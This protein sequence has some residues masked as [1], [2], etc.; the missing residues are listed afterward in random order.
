M[1]IPAL[2]RFSTLGSSTLETR[3]RSSERIDPCE[4]QNDCNIPIV[5][6]EEPESLGWFYPWSV[7]VQ[8]DGKSSGRT[9]TA[10]SAR[11][12]DKA[13]PGINMLTGMQSKAVA[14]LI[15]NFALGNEVGYI[16]LAA[17]A[18]GASLAGIVP[19]R[20]ARGIERRSVL[21][22]IISKGP[23]HSTC[24]TTPSMKISWTAKR[25]PSGSISCP[26][27]SRGVHG[28]HFEL[29][30]L[31]TSTFGTR[32]VASMSKPNT[33]RSLGRSAEL[34]AVSQSVS[35]ATNR[36]YLEGLKEILDFPG[37]ATLI[38]H[39]EPAVMLW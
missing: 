25:V 24:A 33:C 18:Y 3:W 27:D 31:A 19:A 6:M 4:S 1:N 10:L 28:S 8:I 2:R 32:V 11:W 5:L 15:R 35:R 7:S 23:L 9:E 20:P 34:E 21:R 22:I 36:W 12:Q 13:P 14:L 30:F 16:D 39:Y 26:S 38:P 17:V 37:A 29:D